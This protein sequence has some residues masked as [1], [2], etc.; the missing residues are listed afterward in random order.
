M[1]QNGWSKSILSLI[2][3]HQK[4]GGS[5]PT[6]RKRDDTEDGAPVKGRRTTQKLSQNY[7]KIISDAEADIPV[8]HRTKG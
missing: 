1:P 3:D 6:K 8:T 4:S 5:P 2:T 7:E